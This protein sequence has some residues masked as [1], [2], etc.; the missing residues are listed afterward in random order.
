Y[1]VYDM[2]GGAWEYTMGVYNQTIRNSGFSTLPEAKYYDNYTTSTGLKGD[3]TNADG[4]QSWYND[5]FYFVDDG[6]PWFLRGGNYYN[7]TGAGVFYAY[8]DGGYAGVAARVV[9]S[10]GHRS[11]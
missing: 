9:L 11:Y 7:T 3:A 10:L 6:S 2:S 8:S 4:T 1:G 5:N